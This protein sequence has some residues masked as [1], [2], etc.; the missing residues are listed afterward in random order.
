MAGRK[1]HTVLTMEQRLSVLKDLKE[2]SQSVAAI[3]K[4]Y[5][6]DRSTIFRV[7]RN[8]IKITPFEDESRQQKKRRTIKEP[9]FDELDRELVS[10]F[11]ERRTLGD[12]VT[13]A[14]LLEKAAELK[15]RLP[16]CSNF[17]VSHGWLAKFKA[18]HDIRLVHIH[19]EQSSADTNAMKE[20]VET[21][22]KLIEEENINLENVY[23][24]DES[25]LVWKALP[26]KTLAQKGEGNISGYK[27]KKDRITIAFCANALGTHKIKSLVIYKYKNPRAIKHCQETLPVIFKSQKNAW[28]DRTLFTDWF[29]N[30]FKPAAK[31]HQQDKGLNGKIIL[32]VDNCEAHKIPSEIGNKD[33]FQIIYLPP[34]TTS[35]LQPMD[36]GVI[37]KTKRSFRHY[38]LRRVLTYEGGVQE[39][40]KE[41]TIK[42]CIEIVH[43]SW[44]DVTESNIRNSWN[45]LFQ[46]E[47]IPPL[48]EDENLDLLETISQITGDDCLR[49]GVLDYLSACEQAESES[50]EQLIEENATEEIQDEPYD[51]NISDEV[52]RNEL[53]NIFER[54]S[55]YTAT[56]PAHIHYV[57][58]SLKTF[59]LG[60]DN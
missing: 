8:A 34:N 15:D 60:R 55:F 54:L 40:Y 2:S 51:E 56:A 18:R 46:R 17:K 43:S 58:L 3:A 36:Q 37:E 29:E 14:L 30:Y 52:A 12:N 39:F 16:S 42:D 57:L 35:I 38:M 53:T 49:E 1:K 48:T 41:Y 33:G 6:V 44:Q 24:M 25:G 32:L 4:K 21:F 27:M 9:V 11:I 22:T 13:D 20:F 23:N 10:W 50:G 31:Q 45:Q 59:F 7:A 19:G 28:M 47:T 26:R 5:S